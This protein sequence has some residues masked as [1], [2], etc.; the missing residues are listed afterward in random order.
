M[1]E[2][3]VRGQMNEAIVARDWNHAA[4]LYDKHVKEHPI[5]PLWDEPLTYA[6]GACKEK[7]P[8][9]AS[10]FAIH[11]INSGVMSEKHL[12]LIFSIADK[13]QESK[14]HAKAVEL[15]SAT[16]EKG[17]LP[18][19]SEKAPGGLM[20]GEVLADKFGNFIRNAKE[21][22]TPKNV[23]DFKKLGIRA[24]IY[25]ADSVMPDNYPV[26]SRINH[27]INHGDW[28]DVARFYDEKAQ[29]GLIHP[30]WDGTLN[31]MTL[32]QEADAP[33]AA[34][35]IALH[36]IQ[37]G[38]VGPAHADLV[39]S[40]VEDLRSQGEAEHAADLIEKAVE[41]KILTTEPSRTF[42][43]LI[44]YFPSDEPK[45]K[46]RVLVAGV[47]AGIYNKQKVLEGLASDA[48]ARRRA[49]EYAETYFTHVKEALG[50]KRV[51]KPKTT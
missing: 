46:A 35:K 40:I 50:V 28:D 4:D 2:R 34:K 44:T 11:G 29:K 43:R 1:V 27:A 32:A 48:E 8:V 10:R 41:H 13:L 17:I 24:G 51:R 33:V 14:Q 21:S 49:A 3:N 12:N 25:A 47:K 6:K 20:W 15:I 31:H 37:A 36:G 39:Y 5:N 30:L 23:N 26:N 9:A 38:A 42:E 18:K 16:V 22:G 7:K 45:Q 19:Y